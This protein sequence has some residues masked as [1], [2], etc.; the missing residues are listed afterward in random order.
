MT[1]LILG[2]GVMQIPAMRAAREM[3]WTVAVADGNPDATGAG[4]ADR[5]FPV[6]LKDREG[7]ERAARSLRAEAGLDAV[8]T[9]GT[10]FSA[11][12]AWVAERLD[13]P[14]IPYETALRA[15][16]K[17]RMREALAKAGLPSPRFVSLDADGSPRAAVERAGLDFPLVVKP[18][19]SMG[20]RGCRAV[21]D[22]VDLEEALADA[23]PYSR[24]GRVVAEEYLEGPEY[25]IDAL[26]VDGEIRIRGLA[27][28][29]IAFSPY[30]V[31]LGHTMP[32]S[33]PREVADEVLRVFGA[34][35]RA[36]GIERG[37]AKG[38]MKFCPSRGGAFVGEIA[39]RLSGGY[40]SGW[41]YPYASGIEP[42]REALLVAAGLD[43]GPAPRD[44]A[45]VSAERAFI[46]I[47]G[48]FR[49]VV[50]EGRA[51]SLPYIKDFFLRFAMGD[52]LDFPSNN[53]EKCGNV[54]SQAPDRPTAV[55]AADTAIR[56]L[57]VRLLAGEER[58][59]AFLRGDGCVSNPDGSIWPPPAFPLDP[60]FSAVLEA[61]PELL[62][63]PKR[64]PADR[65]VPVSVVRVTWADRVLSRDWAGR[66]FSESAGLALDIA[67][68]VWGSGGR[69]V[70]AGRFWRAL[71][72]G[73]AQAALYVLDCASMDAR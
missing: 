46:S 73:G 65:P 38:D 28:R 51:R 53:V 44:R 32:S 14:G 48:R 42:T 70:L 13:L 71:A 58:T 3:G 12:V 66:G 50:G 24:S 45:W 18:A 34:A 59:E 6:D 41:T 49:A 54:I 67:G 20:A 4:L 62:E 43:P 40:M 56:G 64:E 52:V 39:A 25:S 57:V 68:A 23:L 21:R 47:P 16:D 63:A 1:V 15:S 9:A 17:L 26:V 72:R 61:M 2:A 5:F 37:A 22:P 27:D 35:V 8:F 29:H 11:S 31:E 30:F 19:D 33:A 55:D 60:E 7:L 69:V 10:D 36:I